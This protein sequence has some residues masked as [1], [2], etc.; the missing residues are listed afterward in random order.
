[1]Y[2]IWR[3]VAAGAISLS[4]LLA[5]DLRH[6]DAATFGLAPVTGLFGEIWDGQTFTADSVP[7]IAK[8]VAQTKANAGVETETCEPFSLLWLGN[9]Q[10]HY[11][12]QFEAGDHI[13]PY[14]LRRE[15]E[16]PS[17]ATP[18]GF[19]LPNANLQEHYILQRHVTRRV[20]IRMIL[21]ELCFDDLREEG[22][23]PEFSVLLDDDQLTGGEPVA[24]EIVSRAQAQGRLDTSEENAGLD[25]FVQKGVEDGLDAALS[26][27]WPLW[28]HRQALR[29]SVLSDLYFTRNAVLGINPTTVRKLIPARYDRNMQALEALLRDAKA[30]GI[31]VLA[32][33]APIRQDLP[34]P[35]DPVEYER[36]KAVVG[37]IATN[38]GARLI[39]LETLIPADL[40]G[41]YHED[42]VDFM[43]FRGPGH[44]IIARTLLPH[45]EAVRRGGQ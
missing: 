25:G 34:I 1:M 31:S 18:F 9:S 20:P 37:E 10:L 14:W 44:Q 2:P 8:I 28:S 27:W 11:I 3:C 15:L 38:N 26:E 40:W 39:N 4:L 36:W 13:A 22:L 21:L 7:A 45:V 6:I 32:Y 30:N 5:Y 41:S 19:S 29:V 12:N 24:T 43:H 16:C 33:I 42:D 35:Y 23:R 17:V